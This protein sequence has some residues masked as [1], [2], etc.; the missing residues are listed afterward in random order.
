[1]N[2][3]TC[4]ECDFLRSG[5]HEPPL[6][7]T[8]HFAVHGK[9]EIPAVPGWMIIA[10][11]RHV[12]QVD[13]LDGLAQS[14]LQPLIAR[15]AAALRAA[16]PTA[17]VYVCTWN[18]M[19]SHLHIHVIAR[20]PDFPPERRGARLFLEDAPTD[21]AARQAGHDVARAVLAALG[22]RQPSV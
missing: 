2:S 12:E 3:E 9:I 19:L 11:L 13:A 4:L 16:T 7:R 10:P 17:R 5:A 8:A 22:V 14:E 21:P 6:L 20:P 15:V 18:E 1:V